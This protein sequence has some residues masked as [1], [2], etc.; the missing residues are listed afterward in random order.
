MRV[1]DAPARHT[2]ARRGVSGLLDDERNDA[3]WL[4]GLENCLAV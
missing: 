1:A 3:I 4:R 2:N